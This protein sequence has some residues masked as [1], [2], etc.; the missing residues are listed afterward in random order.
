VRYKWRRRRTLVRFVVLR[1]DG[2]WRAWTPDEMKKA[3]P[4]K[5]V[6]CDKALVSPARKPALNSSTLIS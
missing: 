6:G 2:I 5:P 3:E 1:M 4:P